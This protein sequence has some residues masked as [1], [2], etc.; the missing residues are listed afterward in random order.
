MLFDSVDEEKEASHKFTIYDDMVESY[1]Y[2][3]N[4]DF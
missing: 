3:H 1:V 2:L 4:G